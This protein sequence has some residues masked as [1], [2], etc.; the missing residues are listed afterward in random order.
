[1]ISDIIKIERGYV[2]HP[3]DKGG[4]TKYGITLKTLSVWAGKRCTANDVKN[5]KEQTAYKIYEKLFFNDPKINNL[6]A[7]IQP[8]ILDMAVNHGPERAIKL[9]QEVLL[10][11]GK[12]VGKIDGIIGR[13]TQEAARC[14]F[15]LLGDDLINTIVTRRIN[16][17]KSIVEHDKSQAEFLNGWLTRAES[18]RVAIA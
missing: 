4:P 12:N 15:D 10:A 1:M 14:A 7:Q 11:H 17:Y 16:Y 9:L 18:F 13:L 2:N 3:A 5:L 8:I 6:P